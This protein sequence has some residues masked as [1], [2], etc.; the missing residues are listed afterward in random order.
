VNISNT[1]FT[2]CT[3]ND[4]L[5]LYS[6]LYN[7]DRT[8]PISNAVQKMAVEKAQWAYEIFKPTCKKY[9]GTK[10]RAK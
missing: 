5:P 7:G 6:F 9:E 2:H 4:L 8:L 10:P 3:L 1:I